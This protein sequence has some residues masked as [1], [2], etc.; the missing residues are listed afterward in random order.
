M[1]TETEVLTA[2]GK[3]TDTNFGNNIVDLGFVRDLEIK[4]THVHFNV[5]L[6]TPVFP[7]QERM[8]DEAE[9]MIKGLSGVTSV[10]GHVKSE[11]SR[12]KASDHASLAGVKNIVAIGS[13]KGGVGKSTVAVNIAAGLAKYGARVGLVDGD[14]YGPSLPIM[15]GTREAELTQNERGIIPIEA[16]GMKL[17]SMGLLSRGSAPLIWRGPM[18]HKAVQE[19]LLRVDWG[20]LDYLFVDMPPGTGDVHL[21]LVQTVPLTGAVMVSTP[22]DVG[23]TI[24]MKTL[25]MFEQ[26]KVPI[27]GLIENMSYYLCSHCGERDEIFGYGSVRK[28]AEKLHAP[29]LGEIPLDRGIREKADSG[30][31]AVIAKTESPA[32]RFYLQ[33]IERLASQ[34]HLQ[35]V[36]AKPISI[37]E[38]GE[39]SDTFEV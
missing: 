29:F 16:L 24:S 31:P 13:G 32:A 27:L 23:L 1:A 10:C 33:I 28:E 19:S 4:G 5:V 2:L 14:I 12:S 9:Q 34:I 15:L 18:A 39:T 8:K 20:E 7:G 22:Q 11:I 21:T 25:R 3:V 6:P 30:L 38:E 35:N 17:M 36:K 37:I 26:T